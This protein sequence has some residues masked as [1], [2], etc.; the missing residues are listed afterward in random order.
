MSPAEFTEALELRLDKL[1]MAGRT[2]DLWWRDDDA[3]AST[4]ALTRLLD[5]AEQHEVPIC[6]A[7]I[8]RDSGDDLAREVGRYPGAWV[9]QHGWA[10]DNHEAPG[11]KSAELGAARAVDLILEELAEGRG[12]LERLFGDAF[13]P[14]LIP[15]WNRIDDEVARRRDEAGLP[16]L[17]TFAQMHPRDP[18]CRNTHLDPIAWKRGRAFAGF[19]KMLDILDEELA[20]KRDLPIGLL[21]HHLVH[22]PAVWDFVERFVAATARHEAARWLSPDDLFGR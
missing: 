8:P 22:E 16:W 13:A 10:H 5:L 19:Q 18:L 11:T 1:A 15:P 3:V 6:L 17:S 9:S 20:S 4:V 21:T 2:L 12:R 14:M 7:V